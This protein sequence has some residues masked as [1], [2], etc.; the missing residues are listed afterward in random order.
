MS[1]R[2]IPAH[3]VRLGYA[4]SQS[5]LYLMLGRDILIYN[6]RLGYI[7]SQS[8]YLTLGRDV[9]YIIYVQGMQYPSPLYGSYLYLSS[10]LYLQCQ[11][12]GVTKC[13]QSSLMMK[14]VDLLI[15]LLLIDLGPLGLYED[16]DDVRPR[17]RNSCTSY[18]TENTDYLTTTPPQGQ[19]VPIGL[20]QQVKGPSL[21]K[22][23]YLIEPIEACLL[24]IMFFTYYIYQQ[25]FYLKANLRKQGS[26]LIIRLIKLNV[27]A[28]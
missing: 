25:T 18:A 23:Y 4:V 3:N 6:I 26:F 27:I 10:N 24:Y 5:S 28:K 20:V 1:G 15:I 22:P 12:L 7:L 11:C 16:I 13:I 9:L 2:N 17:A 19:L 14:L 21:Y 8:S